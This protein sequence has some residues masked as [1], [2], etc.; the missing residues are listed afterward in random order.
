M[1]RPKVFISSTIFDFKDLRSAL[2]YWLEEMGF[3]AV[4]S[5][6]NDF[7]VASNKSS[8]DAC[9]KAIEYCDYFILLIGSRAGGFYER[10]NYLSITRKEFQTAYE[11]SLQGK[12]KLIPFIRR[13]VWDIKEDRKALQELLRKENELSKEKKEK[14]INHE[15]SIIQNAESIFQF[16]KEV[17]KS[18]EVNNAI[19]DKTHLPKNNWI[20][21]FESFEDIVKTIRVQLSLNFRLHEKILL[22]N[23]KNELED[24][25]STMFYMSNKRWAPITDWG[26]AARKAYDLG[27]KEDVLLSLEE[28]DSI[29]NFFIFSF[30]CKAN[31]TFISQAVTEG[32]FL[33]YDKEN[34]SF[35]KTCAHQAALILRDEIKRFNDDKAQKTHNEAFEYILKLKKE[36]TPSPHNGV[37]ADNLVISMIESYRDN[38]HNIRELSKYLRNRII[39]GDLDN[40]SF[41]QKVYVGKG[42]MNEPAPNTVW[43][44]DQGFDEVC[45]D[46]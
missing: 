20:Y 45:K 2:K 46:C 39:D 40:K 23:L 24:T 12:I 14:I 28:V 18:K 29:F 43:L 6:N 32:I 26:V 31:N 36:S 9:L 5:E 4:L 33:S 25:L 3:E 1:S 42:T 34:N 19:N 21:I 16:I 37:L 38:I 10:D 30:S 35:L 15:S 8:Y 13:S 44:T 7:Y 17:T 27:V 22:A 11:L 41:Y